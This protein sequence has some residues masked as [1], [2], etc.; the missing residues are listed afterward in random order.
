MKLELTPTHF[1]TVDGQSVTVRVDT[2][3][4]AKHALKELRH[5]KRQL[6][7]H[8]KDLLA[9]ERAA[10]ARE[11]RR[12]R[13]KPKPLFTS[14]GDYVGQSVASLATLLSPRAQQNAYRRARDIRA[15]IE[16]LDDLI[17]NVDGTRLEIEGRLVADGKPG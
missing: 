8:R 2:P 7:H 1:T 14:F 16:R 11:K 13:Q 12:K 3:D 6:R 10:K 15:D 4:E 5:V 9:A 17:Q